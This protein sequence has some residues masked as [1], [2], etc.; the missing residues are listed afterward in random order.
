MRYRSDIDGLRAAAI[1]PV[2]FYH[3]AIPGF[4]GGFVGVDIFFVI[5]GFLISTIVLQDS[6]AGRFSLASFYEHRARRI[7]PAL[8]CVVFLCTAASAVL[9][10]PDDLAAFGKSV[11]TTM[12]FA[13]NIGFWRESGYFDTVATAKPLLHTW[14]LAVEEQFYLLAPL[15]LLALAKARRVFLVAALCAVSAGSLISAALLLKN[16]QAAVFYLLP[17]RIW[18]LG[19]GAILAALPAPAHAPRPVREILGLGGL[20]LIA[21][22]VFSYSNA[23]PF[24]GPN[25]LVPTLGAAFIILA[26][27][28]GRHTVGTMLGLR[29]AVFIGLISYSLYLWHWPLVAYW[30]YIHGPFFPASI[31]FAGVAVAIGLGALS[32][33]YVERPFRGKSG[34][35]SR[36][37]LFAATA[38]AAGLLACIGGAFWLSGGWP[39]RM[40]P[41]TAARVAQYLSARDDI[42][43][44]PPRCYLTLTNRQVVDGLLCRFGDPAA[45]PDFILW[46][47]SHARVL[48]AGFE[49]AARRRHR[50]GLLATQSGCAP[51]LNVNDTA[52]PNC[53]AFN[54]AVLRTALKPG[55]KT[56]FLHGD[57]AVPAEGTSFITGRPI[58]DLSDDETAVTM[59]G[60][61]RNRAVFRRGLER[62]V[63]DLAQAGKQTMIVA[64]V[65]EL[66]WQ[67]PEALAKNTFWHRDMDIRTSRADFRDREKSVMLTLAEVSRLPGV[68]IVYPDRVLCK[69]EY[70]DVME[71]GRLLYRDDNHLSAFG[72]QRVVNGLED[73]LFAQVST[74][75]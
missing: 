35:F 73:K 55:I 9:L 52:A 36:P 65:P 28:M 10:L 51:M 2:V 69:K 64:S 12:M 30:T 46:G 53:R 31:K 44:V 37:S 4:G 17:T 39:T 70:C 32:W 11:V 40:T 18:E 26:G 6:R 27:T 14:S 42:S 21:W 50:A 57:W 1:L 68:E 41:Q 61:A 29:P 60:P 54:Q 38:G 20:A 66:R 45:M 3:F 62:L 75:R 71:K 49:R 13:S 33:R 47:D 15:L 59:G 34:L 58:G 25:A 19:L 23:T 16:H 67:A 56:I 5:S 8:F 72:V 24:P 63:R 74:V 7:L 22:A 48:M 43:A